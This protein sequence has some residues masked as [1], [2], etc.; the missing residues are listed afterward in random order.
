M[1]P[2]ARH[3]LAAFAVAW[4]FAAAWGSLVQTQFNLQALIGLGVEIPATL[5]LQTTAQD[6][7]GFGP[8]YAAIVLAAWLP[9]FAVMAWLGA[10]LPSARTPLYAVAAAAGLVVV[11]RSIDAVA[12]MPVFIDATRSSAGLLAMVAGAALAGAGF[13]RATRASPGLSRR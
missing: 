9:A 10:R 4:L 5:R 3:R 12:P 13:A 11:I 8:L 6:L 1:T 7:L 2:A